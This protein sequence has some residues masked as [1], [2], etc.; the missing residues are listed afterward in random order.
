MTVLQLSDLQKRYDRTTVLDGVNLTVDENEVVALVGP[1]GAGKSTLLDIVV[2][3]THA[4]DGRLRVLGADPRTDVTAVHRRLGVLPQDFDVFEGLTARQH[5]SY[6]VEANETN[7]RPLAL[8]DRVGIARAADR[9]A[10][11]FSRG[12]KQRLALAMALVGEPELLVLDEPFSGVDP[13]GVS[14]L[15]SVVS[16][17]VA[18]GAAV[19]LTSHDLSEVRGLSDRIGIL[20]DGELVA[21]GSEST[22]VS[23]VP[24]VAVLVLPDRPDAATRNELV[25]MAGVSG[26]GERNG[27][28]T[29]RVTAEAAVDRVTRRLDS[30]RVSVTEPTLEDV[31]AYYTLD[32]RRE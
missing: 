9:W 2:N 31:F 11:E 3:Y 28:V 18:R 23:D 12:M 8:L 30:E 1:N 14:L 20:V 21:C 19:L 26:L 6:A 16:D 27:N 5:V 17:E 4:T 22:L 32:R 7:D 10:S 25:A 24:L 13:N 15:R 29:L